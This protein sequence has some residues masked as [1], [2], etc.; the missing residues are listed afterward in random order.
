M[1]TVVLMKGMLLSLKAVITLHPFHFRMLQTR[2]IA[3]TVSVTSVV[4]I[5]QAWSSWISFLMFSGKALYARN[6]CKVLIFL[7]RSVIQ[8]TVILEEKL[9]ANYLT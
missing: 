8:S 9:V 3:N 4:Y 7:K 2:H 1:N 6:S 5:N